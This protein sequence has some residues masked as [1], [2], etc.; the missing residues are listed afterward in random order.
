VINLV[1]Q[2]S[3]KRLTGRA[4]LSETATG[5]ITLQDKI[6]T[7]TAEE[8]VLEHGKGF[9]GLGVVTVVGDPNFTAKNIKLGV[10]IWGIE[11]RAAGGFIGK[12]KGYIP[13]VY[14]GTA[15][16][17]GLLGSDLFTSRASGSIYTET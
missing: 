4:N 3:V 2:I 6:V 10:T 8:Q 16:S 7:P 13:P 17:R 11:G 1:A 15:R 12:S 5:N 14:R 9:D